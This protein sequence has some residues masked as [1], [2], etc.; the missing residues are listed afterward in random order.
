MAALAPSFTSMVTRMN[1]WSTLLF[2]H[3]SACRT[4]VAR[5][6][7]QGRFTEETYNQTVSTTVSKLAEADFPTRWGHFRILGFRAAAD[8][9]RERRSEDAV[10]L[11]M[12][13]VHSKPPL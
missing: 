8:G 3:N 6:W 1:F 2:N 4:L 12:G 11:V 7:R 10:A 9:V 13:D 5:F